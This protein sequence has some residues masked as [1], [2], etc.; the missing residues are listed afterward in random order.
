MQ[1]KGIPQVPAVDSAALAALADTFRP[2]RLNFAQVCLYC[3]TRWCEAAACVKA[4][5]ASLWAPCDDCDGF[6][7]CS[8]CLNGVVEV[9]RVG[10]VERAARVLPRQREAAALFVA[11]A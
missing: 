6:G 8:H 7:S 3:E 4:H 5:A 10:F 2:P 9:D 11:V 1:V